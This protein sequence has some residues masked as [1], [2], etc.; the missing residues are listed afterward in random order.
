MRTLGRK[1]VAVLVTSGA[2]AALMLGLAGTASAVGIGDIGHD[3]FD[4]F[5]EVGDFGGGIF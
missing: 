2:A 1:V 3:V 5:G 4:T